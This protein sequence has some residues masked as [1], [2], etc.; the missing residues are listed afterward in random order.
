MIFA[1]FDKCLRRTELL[2]FGLSHVKDLIV[3]CV[4]D[5]YQAGQG[6]IGVLNKASGYG[7]L[8]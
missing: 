2:S 8:K 3:I 6:R 5:D 1:K 7:E 4:G